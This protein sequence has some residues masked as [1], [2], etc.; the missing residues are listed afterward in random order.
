MFEYLYINYE[1]F[2]EKRITH[3]RISRTQWNIFLEEWKKSAHL[4]IK[5]IG[6]TY[7]GESIH[8]FKWGKGPIK[9]AAWSQMHGDEATATMALIDIYSILSNYTTQKNP[10]W[11]K[12]H[13]NITFYCIPIVNKDGA[14]LWQR[15]T[16]LG[17]DMNRDAQSQFSPEAKILSKWLDDIQPTYSFNLHDQNRL[18]SAG[19]SPYQTQIALLATAANEE[20]T[21]TASRIRAG[22]LANHLSKKLKPIIGNHLA[23]WSDEY[24]ARAFGDSVQKKGYG[25]ILFE[26]GGLQWDLEK[27][28]LRKLTYCM[29]LESFH[30]IISNDLEKEDLNEYLSLPTNDKYITDLKIK[31]APLDHT[32]NSRADLI[33]NIKEIASDENPISF[34]W[35]LE[36][37]GDMSHLYGLTEINGS[38]L[39]LFE[40]KLPVKGEEYDEFILSEN[41]KIKFKLSEYTLKIN[42]TI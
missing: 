33:F 3:R 14:K 38:N 40:D 19:K 37:I 2:K 22:K 12:L 18:Y 30:K 35:I 32:G 7:L 36:D 8:E 28:Y 29:L 31:N 5:E 25:L 26:A 1:Q 23:K 42:Q 13:Q 27:Q 16:A 34:K 41:N 21:W 17:I 6:K 39:S 9:I 20:G 24:E 11:E 4:E 10:F 15:E